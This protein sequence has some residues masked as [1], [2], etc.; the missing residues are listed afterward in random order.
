MYALCWED[1]W[2]FMGRHSGTYRVAIQ[3]GEVV[4]FI[5]HVERDARLATNAKGDGVARFM[6]DAFAEE[7]GELDVQ[8]LPNN[9]RSIGF[10]RKLG[11]TPTAELRGTDPIPLAKSR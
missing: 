2:N 11:Y 3:R 4:G 9:P 6:W 10:F 5:G 7:V 8:V 1:H